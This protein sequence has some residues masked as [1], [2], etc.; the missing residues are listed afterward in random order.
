MNAPSVLDVARF[1]PALESLRGI[2]ALAVCY[3]HSLAVYRL[4]GSQAIWAV[5]IWQQSP[6]VA[7]LTAV[8]ALFNPQVAVLLFF[9]LSG[10][11]LTLS[12][13]RQ[14]IASF[15]SRRALRI[16]PAMWAA[17]LLTY[18]L[19]QIDHSGAS[20]S[21]WYAIDFAQP[22]LR[23]LYR[24]LA[25]ID[26][27]VS[28]VTWT[29]R[30]ELLGSAMMPLFVAALRLRR[31]WRIAV[32][33]ALIAVV[34]VTRT[35]FRYLLCFY[36]GALLT[37]A[38]PRHAWIYLAAGIAVC[39]ALRFSLLEIT[40]SGTAVLIG[41]LGGSLLLAG[42]LCRHFHALETPP[43]RFLGRVSYSLYL[44]HPSM[45]GLAA[46]LAFKFTAAPILGTLMIFALSI[47][48]SLPMAW[49][50]H[51]WIE[52]PSMAAGKVVS[53]AP[54]MVRGVGSRTEVQ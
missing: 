24:N 48:L 4:D 46:I 50:S 37:Q 31:P 1:N 29:I 30:I 20:V 17:L 33:V 14:S 34:V 6:A 22:T 38:R 39:I 16:L 49:A 15:Y 35:D 10:Y 18:A 27:K 8:N 28:S 13:E 2:A 43:V 11:V 26:F 25:L 9:V 53:T 19:N 52:L 36:V 45:L 23:D 51:R 5:P 12:L 3:T 21:D 41:T 32:L 42:V 47:G 40:H 7:A 44:L 54:W